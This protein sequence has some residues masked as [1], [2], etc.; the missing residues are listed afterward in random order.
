MIPGLVAPAVPRQRE[1]AEVDLDST[2]P[3]IG[4]AVRR[5]QA[6]I[7]IC[8]WRDLRHP[9][10]G[11]SELYVEELARSLAKLGNDVTL[12]CAKVEGAAADEILAAQRMTGE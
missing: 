12:L 10:G 8:N 6:R 3:P 1:R 4:G 2:A 9:E 5:G 11:G 7:A